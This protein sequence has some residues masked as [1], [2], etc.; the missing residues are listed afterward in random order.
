MVPR[1]TRRHLLDALLVARFA[2]AQTVNTPAGLTEDQKREAARVAAEL[3]LFIQETVHELKV[4]GDPSLAAV[5]RFQEMLPVM[6][7]APRD[8]SKQGTPLA[9]VLYEV[10]EAKGKLNLQIS[11]FG[12]YDIIGP[13]L[14]ETKQDPLQKE[15]LISVLIKEGAMLDQLQRN[16]QYFVDTYDLGKRF[17]QEG[18]G[19][20]EGAVKAFAAHIVQGE[21]IGYK[22][23]LSYL[24]RRDISLERLSVAGPR[25]VVP[26]IGGL[27]RLYY[28]FLRYSQA[29][30]RDDGDLSQRIYIL[31]DHI[32]TSTPNLWPALRR[33]GL[34]APQ[35]VI[36]DNWNIKMKDPFRFLVGPEYLNGKGPTTHMWYWVVGG[37]G[38]SFIAYWFRSRGSGPKGPSV[39]KPTTPSSNHS[40]LKERQKGKRDRGQ[41]FMALLLAA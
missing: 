35:A 13:L 23:A 26:Q 1:M 20:E 36:D 28:E 8:P 33:F 24:R 4:Q 25:Q 10:L 29:D 14:S 21:M 22:A 30:P 16:P 6:G 27:Y 39:T 7:F 32:P 5:L 15:M 18:Q 12:V 31:L 19:M 11:L 3:G 17:Q 34:P 41:T 37:L 2:A 38:F 40:R 9:G